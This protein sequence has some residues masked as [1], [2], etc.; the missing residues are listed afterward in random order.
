[1]IPA[2]TQLADLEPPLGWLRPQ[3]ERDRHGV[4][5]ARKKPRYR[6]IGS[7]GEQ[8]RAPDLLHGRLALLA[9][10]IRLGKGVPT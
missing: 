5:E 3:A 7:P 10:G 6:S 4:G 9:N 2:F 8:G 1:V